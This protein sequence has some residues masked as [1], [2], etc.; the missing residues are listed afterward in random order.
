MVRWA[1]PDDASDL[2]EV[3]VTSWRTAY[4]GILPAGYLQGLDRSARERWWLGFVTEG[5]R[6]HVVE[7]GGRVVGFCHAGRSEDAGWGEVF[8]IYVHPGHWGRGHGRALL[9]AAEA[10]L[11]DEGLTQALLWVLEQNT[12]ARAFYQR[13]G[14]RP[15]KPFRV[16]EI[17]GAQVTELRYEKDLP[18]PP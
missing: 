12:A 6:V 11:A 1:T 3:H 7:S 16:E 5:A 8:A 4:R 2:A 18:A 10:H 14:W 15:G 13:Q 17:G 9:D